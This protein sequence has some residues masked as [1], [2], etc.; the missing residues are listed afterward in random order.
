MEQIICKMCG[1]NELQL[2]KDAYVCQ[3]CGCKYTT[4]MS[5]IVNFTNKDNDK[6]TSNDAIETV[7]KHGQRSHTTIVKR[8]IK[9][10][11]T[12]QE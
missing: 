12:S 8:I 10:T 3:H 2:E 9:F 4:D 5:E 1:G 6:V 11:H 7:E